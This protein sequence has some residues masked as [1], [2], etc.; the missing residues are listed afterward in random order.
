LKRVM[1]IA[2]SS[3]SGAG[4]RTDLRAFLRCGVYGT[5]ALIASPRE[6]SAEE[7]EADKEALLG[8]ARLERDFWGKAYAGGEE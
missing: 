2:T 4:I 8:V 1:S 7:R 6:G 3:D 5:S